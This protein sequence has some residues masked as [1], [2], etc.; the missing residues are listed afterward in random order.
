MIIDKLTSCEADVLGKSRAK[1]PCRYFT[2]N[3]NAI[4]KALQCHQCQKLIYIK[5]N[6]ITVDECTL[7]KDNLT[8]LTWL[9]LS[10]TIGNNAKIFL[11]TFVSND[12]IL[13]LNDFPML[14]LVDIMPCSEIKS[15]LQNMPNLYDCHSEEVYISVQELS[16]YH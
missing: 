15:N 9:C 8:I 2:K 10:C 12:T 11:F 13:Q 7:I 3:V 1:L 14:S 6:D 5:C 4:Q 16:T